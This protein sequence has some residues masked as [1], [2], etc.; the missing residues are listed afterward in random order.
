[1]DK[2]FN[3]MTTQGKD[4]I[5]ENTGDFIKPEGWMHFKDLKKS[6]YHVEYNNRGP[7]A[8]LNVRVN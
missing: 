2:Q 7:S 3:K 8:N 5:D 6:L 4:F 1:M